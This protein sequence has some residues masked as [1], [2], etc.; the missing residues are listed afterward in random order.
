MYDVKSVVRLFTDHFRKDPES[1]TYKL[2]QLFSDELELLKETNNRIMDWR[3]IDKAEGMTLD[4]IGKNVLQPRGR[5]NDAAYRIA[6]KS[7]IAR[8]LANGT[9]N[10]FIQAVAYIL[11]VDTSKVIVREMW[12]EADDAATLALETLPLDV[13]GKGNL[14]TSD[15]IAFLQS[16]VAAG[17]RILM[18]AS[19]H[20]DITCVDKTYD[21][22]V[23]YLYCNEVVG[24]VEFLQASQVF[25][26]TD[27]TYNYEIEYDVNEVFN[28]TTQN[29]QSIHD[30]AYNYEVALATCGELTTIS[31]VMHQ[32]KVTTATKSAQYNYSVNWLYC[33]E[34][35]A[36]GE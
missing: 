26:I 33:G 1:N 34:F 6:L 8:N 35:E 30:E 24:E 27:K 23:F 2:M 22:P 12:R 5:L 18:V 3:D 7:K 28:T 32:E 16:L 19:A 13:I 11:Q 17:V 31:S 29:E 20:I 4:L 15:F 14:T 9:L 10:G 21:Y 36:G 25:G